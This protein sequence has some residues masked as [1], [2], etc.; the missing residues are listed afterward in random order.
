[1][2]STTANNLTLEDVERQQLDLCATNEKKNHQHKKK[3]KK[4]VK[5]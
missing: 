3:K 4:S 2:S 5:K 1:M